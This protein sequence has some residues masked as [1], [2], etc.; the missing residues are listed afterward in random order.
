MIVWNTTISD[1]IWDVIANTEV[2]EVNQA[3]V[4]DSGG[5]YDSSENKLL[6]DSVIEAD[7]SMD[8]VTTPASRIFYTSLSAM[9]ALL[10]C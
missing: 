6:T 2:L 7:D 3:Y 9:G 5:V 4:G 1:E 8:K 10:F